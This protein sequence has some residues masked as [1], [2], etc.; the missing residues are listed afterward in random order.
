MAEEK[1]I[2]YAP[3]GKDTEY[4]SKMHLRNIVNYRHIMCPKIQIDYLKK[5]D[6]EDDE[7]MLRVD[8]ESIKI[9]ASEAGQRNDADP[10][11]FFFAEESKKSKIEKILMEIFR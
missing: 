2:K 6:F 11:I 7:Y 8:D 4:D 3:E 10:G 5:S 9:K 1:W